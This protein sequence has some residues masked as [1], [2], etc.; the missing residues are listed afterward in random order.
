MVHLDIIHTLTFAK[1]CSSN[2]LSSVSTVVAVVKHATYGI[3][4][5]AKFGFWWNRVANFLEVLVWDRRKGVLCVDGSACTARQNNP[6][7]PECM[8]NG[9]ERY[10]G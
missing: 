9:T 8:V 3:L 10:D 7:P 5:N 6:T 1:G 2:F 4:V